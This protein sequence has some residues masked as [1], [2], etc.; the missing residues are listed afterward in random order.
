M[1][2]SEDF[3]MMTLRMKVRVMIMALMAVLVVTANYINMTVNC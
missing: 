1:D 2:E 3:M